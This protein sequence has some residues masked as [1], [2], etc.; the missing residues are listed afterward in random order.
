MTAHTVRS[1]GIGARGIFAT[2]AWNVALAGLESLAFGAGI[3]L[4]LAALE[5]VMHDGPIFVAAGP[6]S[7]SIAAAL[8]FIGRM[9]VGLEAFTTPWAPQASESIVLGMLVGITGC[10]AGW[11]W[12]LIAA[13]I[14]VPDS[15]VLGVLRGAWRAAALVVPYVFASDRARTRT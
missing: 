4:S 6:A 2:E 9:W 3:W 5:S 1:H 10:G 12:E 13:Y 14:P 15:M 7:A 11:G 8:F